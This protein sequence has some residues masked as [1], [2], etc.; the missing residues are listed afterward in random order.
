MQWCDFL[1]SACI[2]GPARRMREMLCDFNMS[3]HQ[4]RSLDSQLDSRGS[5]VDGCDVLVCLLWFGV[6]G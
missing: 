4:Q 1:S 6:G 5:E 3:I 2:R